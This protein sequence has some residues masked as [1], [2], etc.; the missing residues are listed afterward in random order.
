MGDLPLESTTDNPR[1]STLPVVMIKE[2][3]GR[4]PFQAYDVLA[5]FVPGASL[6]GSVA[7]FEAAVCRTADCGVGN[8]R[9]PVSS[10][11]TSLFKLQT[12]SELVS[13]L[14]VIALILLLAYVG[15]H[16]VA[17]VSASTIDRGLVAKGLGYPLQRLVG[18]QQHTVS[19]VM[20]RHLWLG[21]LFFVNLMLMMFYMS[22]PGVNSSVAVLPASV[23]PWVERVYQVEH[24]LLGAAVVGTGTVAALIA[25]IWLI[26]VDG[27]RPKW[28]AIFSSSTL[29]KGLSGIARS[30]LRAYSLPSRLCIAVIGR[31]SG[32]ARGLDTETSRRFVKRT[33][34]LIGKSGEAWSTSS[35][36]WYALLWIRRHDPGSVAPLENWLRLYSFARNLSCA[37]YLAFVYAVGWLQINGQVLTRAEP[38]VFVVG[39]PLLILASSFAML[40]RYYYLY[41]D[42]FTKFLVRA[43]SNPKL[44][45]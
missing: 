24:L 31:T 36:Y 17:S 21:M 37:F 16:L 29:G 19:S 35:A 4:S 26:G 7:A 25:R 33:E 8:V 40:H 2:S 32:I 18:A 34:G 9:A 1:F 38:S 12:N 11:I 10:V 27:A 20:T 41:A 42:Y 3:S 23:R 45:S 5:Y 43:Y 22:A 39:L 15:G 28:L 44:D 13:D 14:T 30:W 6:L